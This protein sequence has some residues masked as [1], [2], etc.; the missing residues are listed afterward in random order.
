MPARSIQAPF[1]AFLEPWRRTPDDVL[2]T[3]PELTAETAKDAAERFPEKRLLV[4]FFQPHFP[5][6]ESVG[7]CDDETTSE[8]Q[9]VWEGVR[10]GV[11]DDEAVWERYESNLSDVLEY[12]YELLDELDGRKVVSADHG[13]LFGERISPFP[14][15]EYGHPDGVRHPDAPVREGDVGREREP[16][17]PKRGARYRT[18][19]PIVRL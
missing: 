19:G 13:N 7:W 9:H 14:F 11:F 3:P 6:T 12:V 2:V 15:T 1:H 5:P 10:R 16:R 18:S 4:H 17:R 8:L